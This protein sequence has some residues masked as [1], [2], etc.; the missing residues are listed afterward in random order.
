MLIIHVARIDGQQ[1]FNGRS[2]GFGQRPVEFRTIVD[3]NFC[4]GEF[5]TTGFNIYF[6]E[7]LWKLD[8]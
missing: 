1:R 5:S 3:S 7:V 2:K 8:Q 4:F 6:K